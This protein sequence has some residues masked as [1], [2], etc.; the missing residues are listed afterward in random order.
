MAG[1]SSWHLGPLL[2]LVNYLFGTSLLAVAVFGVRSAEV[3]A[4]EAAALSI[5]AYR[6]EYRR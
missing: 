3:G 6:N 2:S 4:E 1:C 5:I